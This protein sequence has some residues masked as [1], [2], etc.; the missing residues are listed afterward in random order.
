MTFIVFKF[1]QI[2]GHYPFSQTLA[3]VIVETV[4]LCISLVLHKHVSKT[5]K[6]QRVTCREF[7]SYVGLACMYTSNNIFTFFLLNETDPGTLI[8]FKSMAPFICA[9]MLRMIGEHINTLQYGCIIL[10]CCALGIL[11]TDD[12]GSVDKNQPYVLLVLSVLVTA[13]SS[14][15]NQRVMQKGNRGFHEQ[16]I[17]LYACGTCTGLIAFFILPNQVPVTDG[18]GISALGLILTQ[19]LYG[20]LV[21]SV[22]KWAGALIKNLSNSLVVGILYAL[23][24]VWYGAKSSIH[25]WVATVMIAVISFLYVN[26]AIR[27]VD[28]AQ[29]EPAD[30][31]QEENQSLVVDEE[32]QPLVEITDV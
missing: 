9:I 5:F 19:S 6:L 29:E 21:S 32:T 20:L 13:T 25:S 26:V 30:T 22:F 11:K 8:A 27:P 31:T 24:I 17:I 12:D 2:N 4:K 14:V 18:W 23:S 10:Q 28:T 1:V 7:L 16:N 15:W 3:V